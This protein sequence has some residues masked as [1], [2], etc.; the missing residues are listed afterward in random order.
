[1]ELKP[2]YKQTEIGVIPEDWEIKTLGDLS[3]IMTGRTPPTNDKSNYGHDIMFV[4][5]GD[6]GQAKHIAKSEK[7]LSCKGFSKAV[8]IPADSIMITCIGSTIGKV[9]VAAKPLATNQQL[10]SITPNT[11]Y[12]R[13]FLYYTLLLSAPVIR[14]MASEQAVPIINK[15]NISSFK[16]PYPPLPEQK[17]ICEPINDIDS[18]ITSLEK[19]IEKK[20]LIK[21]GVMQ[22]LLTGKR[23]LPGFSGE[24]E[25]KRL[26]DIGQIMK[27][28]GLSKSSLSEDGSSYCILYGELFTKYNELIEHPVSKTESTQG[29]RSQNGDVLLPGSTTTTGIDLAKASALMVDDALIG[30]DI[31]VLRPLDGMYGPYLALQINTLL[32]HKIAEKTK[33][34]TIYHLHGKDLSDIE[35]Q[36]PSFEEQVQISHVINT[37]ENEIA[38]LQSKRKKHLLLKQ[39]MMQELLTGRIRLI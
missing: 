35:V 13:D 38:I 6:L 21:Q 3:R 24:W 32:K 33:G 27:G 12:D 16:I 28:S 23:R 9:G 10:N 4:G 26:G 8:Q 39:A 22:E 25:T 31:N 7:M 17:Q 19:L 36:I 18:L 34:I 2:G 30:G 37:L 20:K 11:S 29:L 14:T 5:P 15:T 1:M